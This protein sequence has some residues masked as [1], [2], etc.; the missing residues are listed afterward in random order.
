VTVS[1]DAFLVASNPNERMAV[2]VVRAWIEE[3]ARGTMKIRVTSVSR[4]GSEA[5]TLGVASEIDE[6]CALVRG[7]LEAF[8]R[9]ERAD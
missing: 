4:I 5:A 8:A 3:D 2:A 1:A 6:A 9:T 7:W